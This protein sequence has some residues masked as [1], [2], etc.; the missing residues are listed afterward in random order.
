MAA[1]FQR[2][3]AGNERR[4]LLNLA[5]SLLPLKVAAFY[6][7]HHLHAHHH[8]AVLIDHLD[9]CADDAAGRGAIPSGAPPLRWRVRRVGRREIR[10]CSSATH[11]R[12]ESR[13]W[14][15]ERDNSPYRSASSVPRFANRW[16][17]DLRKYSFAPLPYLYETRAAH[18]ACRIRSLPVHQR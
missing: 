11:R 15:H 16:R 10:A 1:L 4:R 17:S 12:R 8:F 3:A 5:V 6:K 13:D 14:R 2:V 9:E 7:I 18:T